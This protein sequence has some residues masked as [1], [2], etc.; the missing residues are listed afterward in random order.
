[1]RQVV[2]ACKRHPYMAAVQTVSVAAMIFCGQQ[3]WAMNR[4]LGELRV[5]VELM[6]S[7]MRALDD[8]RD[9]SMPAPRGLPSREGDPA[10]TDYERPRR[11]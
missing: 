10:A 7:R 5:K 2:D 11:R 3:L 1:M 9:R 6:E 8:W 4:E